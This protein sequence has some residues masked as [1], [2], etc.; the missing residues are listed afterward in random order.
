MGGAG[1]EAGPDQQSDSAGRPRVLIF[2][3][4]CDPT[5][6]SEA[7]V[8][9]AL[10]E[11]AREFADCTVLVGPR[12][13]RGIDKWRTAHDLPP[14]VDYVG[15]M[16]DRITRHFMFHRILFFTHY[17]WWMRKAYRVGRSLHRERPFDAVHHATV[18]VYWLPTAAARLGLPLVWGPVG[19]A[20]VVPRSLISVLGLRGVLDEFLDMVSVRLASMLPATRNTWRRITVGLINND[21]TLRRLPGHLRDRCQIL[22]H[23]L[24]FEPPTCSQVERGDYIVFFSSLETRKGPRL[25]LEA[26]ARTPPRVTLVFAGDGPELKAL[27]RRAQRLGV[28]DRVVFRTGLTRAEAHQVVLGAAAAL[29]TGLREEGGASLAEVMH[30]GLPVIV[31]ANGGARKVAQA[32]LDERKVVLVEPSSRDET[33]QRIADAMTSLTARPLQI[34][35]SNLARDEAVARFRRAFAVALGGDGCG[36]QSTGLYRESDTS[37]R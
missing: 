20:T 23:V 17:L 35:G 2:A 19:G 14:G 9:W 4:S 7:G 11:T 16:D 24:F 34:N 37:V 29:F 3:Y 5:R 13:M 21:E 22:N 8:G 1:E 30:L 18:S 31:L 33:A 15:I 28:S 12:S 25:A 32:S 36:E 6:G 26:L 27:R 10:V